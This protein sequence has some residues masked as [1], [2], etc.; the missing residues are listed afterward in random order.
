MH[1]FGERTMT[2]KKDVLEKASALLDEATSLE[3][4]QEIVRTAARS[5]VR[6][7]GATFVLLEGDQCY[8][9]DEDSMSPLWKGQRFPASAC[10][11]GWAMRHRKT[12]VIRDIRS[13]ER[14][15]QSA[16]QPTF[17]RSLVI[18]PMLGPDPL[19]AIGAYWARLHQ[20]SDRQVTD[21]EDL[22]ALAR[23]SVE[24]F[25]HGIPD[26]GFML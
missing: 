18:A 15:P 6:A 1:Q 13:D 10:I 16:Y 14:I 4:V 2:A 21:L 12:V 5:L 8:Y 7:Q 25:P 11:S 3:R 19:G 26:P 24:R 20:A 9:A 22:A 23:R 17:V